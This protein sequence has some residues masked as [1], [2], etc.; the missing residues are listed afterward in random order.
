MGSVAIVSIIICTCKPVLYKSERSEKETQKG[1][2]KNLKVQKSKRC[3]IVKSNIRTIQK[4]KS[5]KIEKFQYAKDV[6]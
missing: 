6:K 4:S 2:Y 3:E 5:S 1:K